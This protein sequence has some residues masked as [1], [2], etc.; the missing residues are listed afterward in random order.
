M[1][2]TQHFT[3]PFKDLHSKSP[4]TKRWLEDDPLRSFSGANC[5]SLRQVHGHCWDSF[6]IKTF[7]WKQ[8]VVEGRGFVVAEIVGWNPDHTVV[9][10]PVGYMDVFLVIPPRHPNTSLDGV[11]SM[12]WGSK[13]LLS[14]CPWMSRDHYNP[15]FH[16]KD[17]AGF[18]GLKVESLIW[19][20]LHHK[21]FNI[22]TTNGHYFKAWIT[23][24]QTIILGYPSYFSA[25]GKRQTIWTQPACC[26][27]KSCSSCRRSTSIS[28]FT[29]SYGGRRKS[30]TFVVYQ[31]IA[32]HII[33][34]YFHHHHAL[35][36][37]P[38]KTSRW[39][40]SWGWQVLGLPGFHP[41]ISYE[42]WE[43]Y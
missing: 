6:H 16:W 22:D 41:Q 26:K 36:F 27:A 13:Y 32:G 37:G 10:L 2:P 19:N 33:G 43:D 28:C 1:E 14:R 25:V 23:D 3:K 35:V 34:N 20:N 17:V 9:G 24:F 38:P 29:N 11:L 40:V 5:I 8:L 7:R 39:A 4:W 42:P 31:K 30:A 18:T 15:I 12:F 21:K